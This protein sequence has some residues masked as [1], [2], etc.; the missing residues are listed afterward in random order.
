MQQSSVDIGNPIYA[1][2]WQP[3]IRFERYTDTFQDDE[4]NEFIMTIAYDYYVYGGEKHMAKIKY[5]PKPVYYMTDKSMRESVI[6]S[7]ILHEGPFTLDCTPEQY[8]PKYK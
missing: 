4:G 2:S 7:L 6:E 5:D 8:E 1:Q 3:K